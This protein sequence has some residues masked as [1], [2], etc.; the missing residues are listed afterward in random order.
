MNRKE[1][2]MLEALREIAEYKL[3]KKRSNEVKVLQ[4]IAG[5]AIQLVAHIKSQER[6]DNFEV[7]RPPYPPN[8]PK[9]RRNWPKKAQ[10]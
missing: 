2:I 5:K 9:Y 4:T 3:G 7:Y 1:D 10:V 6:Y 8:R